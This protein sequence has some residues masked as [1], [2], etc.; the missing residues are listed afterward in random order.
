MLSGFRKMDENVKLSADLTPKPLKRCRF[1]FNPWCLDRLQE[2]S[3]LGYISGT[4]W[5]K[6]L[7][8]GIDISWGTGV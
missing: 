3:C 2:K 6:M 5:C 1:C 7:I 4:I 8:F